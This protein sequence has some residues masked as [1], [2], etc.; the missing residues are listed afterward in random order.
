MGSN[1]GNMNNKKIALFFDGPQ[2]GGIGARNI[3]LANEYLRQGH[4]V[5]LVLL[6]TKGPRE[7]QLPKEAGI[8]VI[9]PKSALGIF[10]Y[11]RRFLSEEK[12]DILIATNIMPGAIA[13]M[14]KMATGV[15]TS[16][17]I[18]NRVDFERVSKING[19]ALKRRLLHVISPYFI[20]TYARVISLTQAA[21]PGLARY[22]KCNEDDLFV[23]YDPIKIVNQK[24]SVDDEEKLLW[25]SE[26]GLKVLAVGRLD[27]LKDFETTIRSVKEI[28]DLNPRLLI[29]G[30]GP[31]RSGLESLIIDLGLEDNI[32]LAGYSDRP[33]VF[34]KYADIYISSSLSEAFPNTVAEAVCAGLQVV[35]ADC[36]YGPREILG[37]NVWGR[38]VP[39]QDPLAIAKVVREL[40]SEPIP[41]EKLLERAKSFEP[42]EI[43]K[44]IISS[45]S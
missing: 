36:N 1:I 41:K 13:S 30:E 22:I 21:C 7:S 24:P 31:E 14:A 37:D 26:S 25:W 3:D 9:G 6:S 23:I 19:L 5:I 15:N 38:L 4:E 8:R 33:S 20:R 42:T 45:L 32:K 35:A 44:K 2:M 10:A 29:V 27:E 28:I 11:L 43:A 34:Y 12:P 18:I 40:I 39:L 16:L 17:G